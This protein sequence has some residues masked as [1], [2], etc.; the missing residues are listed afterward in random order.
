MTGRAGRRGMDHIG[1]ALIIPG[2]FMDL[3]LIIQ[4]LDAPPSDV[5]SQ[6]KINF[7]MVLNLLLSHTPDE[8]EELLKLS[9]AGYRLHH[10]LSAPEGT[11][12]GHLWQDFLRHLKFLKKKGYVGQRDALTDEGLWASRLRVDHPLLIAESFRAGLFPRA[13]PRLMAALMAVFVNEKETDDRMDKR[14]LPR[15][16]L[17]GYDRLARKMT[18]FMEE[19]AAWGFAGRALYLRPA[20]ALYAWASGQAWERVVGISE[21]DEGNLATL[22]LRTADHLRHVRGLS[23]VFPEAAATADRAI[24]LILKDPVV[25]E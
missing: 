2:R 22:I 5:E 15:P 17:N 1:F 18:P 16:L 3:R 25:E 8:I 4:L 12:S 10:R 20:A 14:L 24:G 9:F 7:S 23:E 19:M 21:M 11:T 13:D 6:I